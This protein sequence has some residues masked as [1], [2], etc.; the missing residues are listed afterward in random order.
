ML[1]SFNLYSSLLLPSFIHGIL[2]FLILFFRGKRD[3]RVADKLLAGIV[4]IFALQVASWMLGFAGW[5]D[6]HDWHTTFMFYAPFNHWLLL[7]PLLYFYFLTVTNDSFKWQ[8]KYW[9][10]LLPEAIWLLRLLWLFT[11]DIVVDHWIGGN[12]LPHFYNTHGEWREI[13]WGFLD[14]IWQF[15]EPISIIFYIMLTLR[16]FRQY[17][18]YIVQ[19]FSDTGSIHFKW[20]RN[21]L[22]A[23][24][25]GYVVLL[26]FDI[27][28]LYSD[29]GLNYV[30]DWY[31]FFF[32]GILIYYLS[33]SGF[34]HGAL[35]RPKLQLNFE[36]GKIVEEDVVDDK[37]SPELIA[38]KEKLEE[39]M[40]TEKLFLHSDLSLQQLASQLNISTGVLSKTINVGFNK[41]FNEFINAF[42]V[43]EVKRKLGDPKNAHLTVLAVGME[44]GFS[45]KATF[46]R[47]FKKIEGISP[48][49]YLSSIDN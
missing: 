6:S 24:I 36:P 27:A 34:A 30:E 43:E 47:V 31:S 39:V 38:W 35:D 44:S 5:Y 13:G 10:H 2:F 26:G 25:I 21:I 20:L 23:M 42:R 22:I 16:L 8:K 9:W 14:K 4:L 29:E 32:L 1:F 45:S 15:A 33:I 7:G 3:D 11:M 48:S 46:N 40:A 37:V 41:N 12:E 17:Q 18:T 49:Q 19:N 28:D